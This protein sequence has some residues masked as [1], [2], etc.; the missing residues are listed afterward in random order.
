MDS[1]LIKKSFEICGFT[2]NSIGDCHS[3]LWNFYTYRVLEVI[4]DN[5]GTSELRGFSNDRE[6]D[7]TNEGSANLNEEELLSRSDQD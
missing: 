7:G 5:D 2:K 6:E 3:V 1:N 4:D